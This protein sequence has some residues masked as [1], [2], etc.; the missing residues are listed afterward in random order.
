MTPVV[1]EFF[2]GLALG[3]GCS[4]LSQRLAPLL[5]LLDYPDDTHKQ[6]GRTVAIGGWALAP[7]MIPVFV[8][9][10]ITELWKLALGS[11][12]ALLT[13]LLDDRFGLSPRAK[14]LGQ[15]LSALIAVFVSG[16]VIQSVNLFGIELALGW[17]A[18]PCTLFW[19]VGAIN[20]FNLIDGLDGL[21]C[22]GALVIFG[23]TA[24]IAW[25]GDN[26]I[27]LALSVGF[28]GTLLG[29]LFFNWAPARVF[30]GD[31]GTHFVGYWLAVFSIQATG[32]GLAP[33]SV[34]ILLSMLLL[35]VPILDT[36]WA[37]LRRLLNK[38][39]IFQADR[40]HL[41]HRLLALGLS[42]RTTVVILSGIFAVLC[43]LAVVI[44]HFF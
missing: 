1:R 42:E 7:A 31:G 39:P 3:A 26:S 25:Y 28:I 36:A 12:V 10:G 32:P 24:L 11:L 13:G 14:L 9:M 35:G 20:A 21:A 17:L 16:W 19:I 40:G 22:G 41:H 23:A 29:F 4:Y 43:G 34:P 37:I 2:V 30:L 38:K 44:S 5:G 8:L 15:L 33:E 27:V 18:I 6:H